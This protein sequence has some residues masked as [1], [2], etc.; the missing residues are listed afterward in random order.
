M[1]RLH[2]GKFKRVFLVLACVMIFLF[3]FKTDG[4]IV[5]AEVTEESIKA[6]KDQIKKHEESASAAARH[7]RKTPDIAQPDGAA[8]GQHNESQP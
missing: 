2:K 3:T 6:K 4:I 5:S 7:I 1:N 8:C